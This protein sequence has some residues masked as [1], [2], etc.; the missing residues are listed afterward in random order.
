[1]PQIQSVEDAYQLLQALGASPHLIQHL[2]LV[3]ETAELLITQFQK[4]NINCDAN[5]IRL[6]TAIHDAGKILYPI[7]IQNQSPNPRHLQCK[8]WQLWITTD[9]RRIFQDFW[10]T[11]RPINMDFAAF[12]IDQ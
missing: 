7:E 11:V 6:G 1:M 10:I 3:G 2:K 4:H 5:W 8:P 9:D 12:T